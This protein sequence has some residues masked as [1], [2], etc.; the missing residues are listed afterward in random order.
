MSRQAPTRF[1]DEDGLVHHSI[2]YGVNTRIAAGTALC[3]TDA[4][5]YRIEH[6]VFPPGTLA[7]APGQRATCLACLAHP[8]AARAGAR[9]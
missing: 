8:A 5:G 1:V 4:S 2:L 9:P 7:E 3:E 6:E